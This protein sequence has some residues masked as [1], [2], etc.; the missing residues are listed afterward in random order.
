VTRVRD[1]LRARSL[2]LAVM[3]ALLAA[4]LAAGVAHAGGRTLDLLP[5]EDNSPLGTNRTIKAD[6]SAPPD[7][8]TEVNI[9]FEVTGPSDPDNGNTPATPDR[10]CTIPA[11]ATRCTVGYVGTIA[12]EDIDRG[13]IDEDGVN[14]TVEAD[15]AEGLDRYAEP[16]SHVDPDSTDVVETLWFGGLTASTTMD[17][18]PEALAASVGAGGRVSC[19]VVR[20]STGERVPGVHVDGENLSGANDTDGVAFDP[21][22]YDD[23][24]V[25]GTN[26]TCSFDLADRFPVAEAGAAN[27]C[28]WADEDADDGFHATEEFDGGDCTE[29][30]DAPDSDNRTDVLRVTWRYERSLLASAITP[31]SYLESFTMSGDVTSDDPDCSGGADVDITKT[32]ADGTKRNIG[33]VRSDADGHFSMMLSADRNATLSAAAAAGELCN[34]AVSRGVRMLVHKKV[35]LGL[36]RSTVARGRRVRIRA[37]IAPCAGKAGQRVVLFRSL[38][39]G[40]TFARVGSKAT[41]DGCVAV[42]ERRVRRHTVFRVW[43]P[44]QDPNHLGGT[45]IAKAV[46]VR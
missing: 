32:L 37:R 27:V 19:T 1:T 30:L 45:S 20:Q 6:I 9:D 40:A 13:W 21:A 24:C 34:A 33:S 28:V 39:R 17:C 10:T 36:S 4:P 18:T 42:F 38:N 8:G 23:L 25:T 41:N 35:A 16:G 7:A 26:G 5:E 22:D 14:A 2:A 3:T 15:M 12:G 46:D 31:K 11:G 29:S 43:S 44:K